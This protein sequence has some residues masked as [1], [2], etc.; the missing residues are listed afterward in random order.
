MRLAASAA[1][2]NKSEAFVSWSV[3][4]PKD[5]KGDT[6]PQGPVG[7][8]GATGPQ[9][10]A[11]AGGAPGPEGPQG[12]AGPEGP[13]GAAEVPQ[14]VYDAICDLYNA[15]GATPLP[16]YCAKIIFLTSAYYTGN[17]GG[18]AGADEKCQTAATSAGLPGTYKAWLSN[19]STSA[20]DRWTHSNLAYVRTD[21][22]II[23]ADWANLVDGSMALATTINANEYGQ[24][25]QGAPPQTI[26]FGHQPWKMALCIASSGYHPRYLLVWTGPMKVA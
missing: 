15:S 25:V 14:S 17:L 21:G 16:D 4:G 5:D 7:L 18:L 9:G 11:G 24:Y 6:G 8:T 10:P 12:P 19:S 13:A 1:E 20:A 2:C 26:M 23:A 22:E 3:Q